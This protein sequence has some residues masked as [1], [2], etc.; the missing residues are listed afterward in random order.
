MLVLGQR[1]AAA[2]MPLRLAVELGDEGLVGNRSAM[3]LSHLAIIE[4]T[5]GKNKLTILVS[6]P[7][8]CRKAPEI[9]TPASSDS[10]PPI[11]KLITDEPF[12]RYRSGTAGEGAAHLRVWMTAGPEP[13]HLAAV[14]ET[15]PAADVTQSAGQIQAE[16]AHRYGAALVLLEHHLAPETGE[17]TETLDLVRI[18]ADGSPHWLRIW[19]TP[20]ENSRHA[21]LE[22]WMAL[23]GH[24]IVSTPASWFDSC[25]DRPDARDHTG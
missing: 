21:G 15:G 6:H 18:G 22:L 2:A 8:T 10:L 16:L 25:E 4:L 12:W 14:T 5:Y 13:G 23:H 1:L 11:G 7:L 17:G 24:R 19:P 3:I 20:E 9:L